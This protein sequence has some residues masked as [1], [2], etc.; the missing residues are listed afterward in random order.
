MGGGTSLGGGA[1]FVVLP[2]WPPASSAAVTVMVNMKIAEAYAASGGAVN[3]ETNHRPYFYN[4]KAW[5]CP[6]VGVA[7]TLKRWEAA[8]AK[9]KARAERTGHTF[10]N[11]YTFGGKPPISLHDA[12]TRRSKQAVEN[13]LLEG[14]DVNAEAWNCLPEEESPPTR[15][16]L[17]LAPPPTGSASAA[18]LAKTP[19][20][21]PSPRKAGEA[22]DVATQLELLRTIKRDLAAAHEDVMATRTGVEATRKVVVKTHDVVDKT[23]AVAKENRSLLREGRRAAAQRDVA[24]AQAAQAVAQANYER[25]KQLEE[26]EAQAAATQDA[27]EAAAA[28]SAAAQAAAEKVCAAMVGAGSTPP[29]DQPDAADPS[30]GA[31]PITAAGAKPAAAGPPADLPDADSAAPAAAPAFA[32][33]SPAPAPGAAPPSPGDSPDVPVRSTSAFARRPAHP[34]RARRCLASRPTHHSSPATP[35]LPPARTTCHPSP[36]PLPH[37]QPPCLHAPRT[38]RPFPTA[39]SSLPPAR[40]PCITAPLASC[41]AA[42]SLPSPTDAVLRLSPCPP[43]QSVSAGPFFSRFQARARVGDAPHSTASA[44]LGLFLT[45]AGRSRNAGAAARGA[46]PHT[47]TAACF[48]VVDSCL[49]CTQLGS[50]GVPVSGSSPSHS[51]SAS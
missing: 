8:K 11:G 4:G 41:P 42:P 20:R 50:H 47:A 14:K 28:N 51:T 16:S 13:D 21:T 31:V 26:L 6:G 24:A 10:D 15:K 39:S 35:G 23:H 9:T 30:P 38:A 48:R 32:A 37:P 43:S 3:T 49:V 18:M 12:L 17:D 40:T 46:W 2:P 1:H 44:S 7:A 27:A 45:P 36:S 19:E 25:V 29:A 34:R 33:L 22:E 5:V